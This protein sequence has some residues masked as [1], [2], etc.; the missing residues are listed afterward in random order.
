MP[1]WTPIPGRIRMSPKPGITKRLSEKPGAE[2][3]KLHCTEMYPIILMQYLTIIFQIKVVISIG[4]FSPK[5][6][7]L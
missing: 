6:T 1:S 2:K 7:G 4:F 5:F 3:V